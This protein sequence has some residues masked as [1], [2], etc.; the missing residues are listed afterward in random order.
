MRPT[1]ISRAEGAAVPGDEQVELQRR[2][3]AELVDRV[4]QDPPAGL[5]ALHG[6]FAKDVNRL[7]WRLLGADA[8]HEDIVQQVFLQMLRSIHHLRDAER[9]NLWVRS[10][11]VNVVRSELRRRTVRRAFLREH[12]EVQFH[13]DLSH[14]VEV[15]ELVRA[16][17]ELLQKMPD[18][19]R[20][21]FVLYQVEGLSLPEVAE[22]CGYSLMTAKRRLSDARRRFE[23][24]LAHRPALRDKLA[25]REGGLP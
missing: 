23:V 3:N 7:V 17:V 6:R 12:Q 20:V 25:Q 5:A 21:V 2:L 14:E 4:L 9:L 24:L 11:T 13:G 19:E 18:R 22:L 8:E 15:R 10:I 16:S 1:K